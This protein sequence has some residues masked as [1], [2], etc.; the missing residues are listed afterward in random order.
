MS[1]FEALCKF[2]R[3]C[4]LC[5]V[6]VCLLN[7]V[8]MCLCIYT[9]MLISR[10]CVYVCVCVCVCWG[11]RQASRFHSQSG[12]ISSGRPKSQPPRGRLPTVGTSRDDCPRWGHCTCALINYTCA[13]T[14]RLTHIGIHRFAYNHVC[15]NMHENKLN[16]MLQSF[17]FS[18]VHTCAHIHTNT[19]TDTH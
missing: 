8:C 15:T 19:H 3:A 13:L 1:V 14:N 17:I 10:V 5:T 6:T 12:S 2:K 9:V 11:R 16:T 4:F 18:G 7:C